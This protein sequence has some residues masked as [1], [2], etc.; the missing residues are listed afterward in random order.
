MEPSEA[1]DSRD[2]VSEITS[3]E[4]VRLSSPT[5]DDYSETIT[6]AASESTPTEEATSILPPVK[7]PAIPSRPRFWQDLISPWLF[8]GRAVLLDSWWPEVAALTVSFAFLVETTIILRYYN[9][10]PV[11]RLPLGLT[12]NTMLALLAA[13]SKSSLI[14]S[15]AATMSQSK[16][17]WLRTERG[18]RRRLHHLQVVEEASRGPL[19]SVMLLM[20]HTKT[21]L[22]YMG[23]V[24]TI[25]SL[26]YEPFIQQVVS[27]PI[28][29]LNSTSFDAQTTVAWGIDTSPPP[30]F[31]QGY[32]AT[33]MVDGSY[34]TGFAD[35]T[36]SC[37]T[38]NCTWNPFWS[39]DWCSKCTYAPLTPQPCSVNFTDSPI[40]TSQNYQ[41]TCDYEF[42][43]LQGVGTTLGATF[44]SSQ[45]SVSLSYPLV[46]PLSAWTINE[47]NTTSVGEYFH[48]ITQYF[49]LTAQ[50]AHHFV[51]EK[52]PLLALGY[53]TPVQPMSTLDRA[54]SRKSIDGH[55]CILTPC[56]RRYNVS[57]TNGIPKRSP[58]EEDYGT[59]FINEDDGTLCWR[60]K[61][62]T[63][64]NVVYDDH[65]GRFDRNPDPAS[66]VVSTSVLDREDLVL[67]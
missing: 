48:T 40:F 38:G 12:L 30:V 24:I 46:W 6:I 26:A 51:D 22:L 13:G 11:S 18:G 44:T 59:M 7:S 43:E 27:Y 67:V 63:S 9:G 23:A 17:C 29:R 47:T 49:N 14:F 31:L 3:F 57:V 8:Y 4:L 39:I 60:P 15:V 53:A 10:N 34:G 58:L 25:L 2:D 28:E 1:I 52:N 61:N 20:G 64:T 42:A 16:W 19:G 41:Q 5:K 65:P 36:S 37:S 35:H 55:I 66:G 32:V 21:S 54:S 33:G 56:S 50:E 62:S 45:S